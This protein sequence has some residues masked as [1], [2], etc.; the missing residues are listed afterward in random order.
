MT[1]L[2][3]RPRSKRSEATFRLHE[4]MAEAALAP[5]G[6][7]DWPR[8]TEAVSE[9]LQLGLTEESVIRLTSIIQSEFQVD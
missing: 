8:I 6:S 3:D 9:L 2:S 5:D 4:A 7:G 1:A